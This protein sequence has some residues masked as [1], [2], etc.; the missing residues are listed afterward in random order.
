MPESYNSAKTMSSHL[1]NEN[2]RFLTPFSSTPCQ[3]PPSTK[4]HGKH[5]KT[6]VADE[7]KYLQGIHSKKITEITSIL[8]QK[9]TEK[10]TT[11]ISSQ[12]ILQIL[13]ATYIQNIP[14]RKDLYTPTP[15]LKS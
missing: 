1:K 4:T 8:P 6:S 12:N 2:M 7:L 13:K 9:Y 3:K 10:F 14:G 15:H 11:E 5:Q